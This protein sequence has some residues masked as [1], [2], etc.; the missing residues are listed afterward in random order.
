MVAYVINTSE[1]KTFDSEKLFDLAGY[2]KI[3][4]MH[5]SLNEIKTC[6]ESIYE[7][8]NVLGADRFRIAVI[9]DFYSFDRIRVPYGRRGFGSEIGVDMSLYMPYIET[10]LLDN[11]IAYLENKDMLAADFE[12]YYVQNEK[13]ELYE[14]LDSA[15]EQ[16]SQI[17]SGKDLAYTSEETVTTRRKKPIP[18]G[19]IP[20]LEGKD[21]LDPEKQYETVTEKVTKEYYRSFLLYCTQEVSLE[22]KMTDYPYGTDEM[23]FD[24]FFQA[25][26]QRLA[27]KRGVRRHYFTSP[28]GGGASRAAFDTLSLSLYLI[29]MYEREEEITNEG[30]MEVIHLEPTALRDVIEEAWAK[31]NAAKDLAKFNNLEYYSLV[32]DLNE[33]YEPTEIPVESPKDAIYRERAALPKEIMRTSLSGENYYKEICA[34]AS[35]S[36]A[37]IKNRNRREFDEIMSEYLRKRDE[38]RENSVEQEFRSL[39]SLGM[40]KMTNQ[41]PS[42]S[43][44]EHVTAQKQQ[45]ISEIF[46]RVLSAEYVNVDYDAEKKKADKA[47]SEYKKAKALMHRNLIGD[48]IFMVLSVLIMIAPYYVFQLTAYDSKIFSSVVLCL[49]AAGIFGGLFVLSVMFR[50]LPIAKKLNAAKAVLYNCYLD[51]NAKERYSFSQIREKYERDLIRIEQARYDLRQMK[52]LFEANR[53]MN[54]NVMIHRNTLEELEDCLAAMLN[55]LDVEPVLDPSISVE[56]E[57]DLSKPI[58][59]RENKVYQIFSIETIERMFPKKGRDER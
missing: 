47:Y 11:L 2:N 54:N 41:T 28:H 4:W 6:A 5:C 42:Q 31:V 44:Y 9:V 35:R 43:E 27:A 10:Y 51:C 24:Q 40:L 57:F 15:K 13:G 1:N 19:G 59:S 39:Q 12:V 30:E 55:N 29:R 22:F 7:K 8:Q 32:Q 18:V 33:Y 34:F 21:L 56:D 14:L 26:K 38:T 49:L 37:D 3:R 46:E 20:P 52:H 50:I 53:A 36:S 48:I 25:T 58:R 45:E 23:T 16:L 17:I